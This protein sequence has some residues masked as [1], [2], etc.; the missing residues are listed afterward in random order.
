[1]FSRRIAVKPNECE[2]VAKMSKKKQ[3]PKSGTL[4]ERQN[5]CITPRSKKI[6]SGA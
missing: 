6:D 3:D 1:M 4:S 2:N 5:F